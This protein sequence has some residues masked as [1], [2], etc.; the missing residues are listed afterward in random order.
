MNPTWHYLVE[1]RHP[2]RRQ[3]WL[4]DRKLMA[5]TVWLDALTNS[6]SIDETATSWELPIEAVQEIFKYCESHKDFIE[7]EAKE[8]RCRLAIRE[9]YL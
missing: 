2:W 3:L 8:E 4:R 9:I 5:S 7:A 6:M 1:R